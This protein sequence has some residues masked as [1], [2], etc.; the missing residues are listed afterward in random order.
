MIQFR[1]RTPWLREDIATA[2]SKPMFRSNGLYKS[3][4]ESKGLFV[5][6]LLPVFGSLELFCEGMMPSEARL[7]MNDLAIA[8]NV[9]VPTNLQILLS[10]SQVQ[11]KGAACLFLS[12]SSS[13]LASPNLSKMLLFFFQCKRNAALVPLLES[14]L[15]I[16]RTLHD[17]L[18]LQ[19]RI[20]LV[21]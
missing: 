6:A 10:I 12:I 11:P 15:G 13:G 14:S 4:S 2:A 8:C 21:A 5:F 18:P 17:A 20:S 1:S 9:D 19:V 7:P 16:K 3:S